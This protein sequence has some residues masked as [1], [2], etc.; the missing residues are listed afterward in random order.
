VAPFDE[1]IFD[2]LVFDVGSEAAP[3]VR[4]T[5]TVGGAGE[6]VRRVARVPVP[7]AGWPLSKQKAFRPRNLTGNRWIRPLG[8]SPF[9]KWGR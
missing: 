1:A 6:A 3:T 4:S 2:P 8:K 9:K 5:A 7:K